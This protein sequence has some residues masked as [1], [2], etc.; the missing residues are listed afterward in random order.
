MRLDCLVMVFYVMNEMIMVRKWRESWKNWE[1]QAGQNSGHVVLFL[2]QN[3]DA[4]LVV[5]LMDICCILCTKCL[6]KIVLNGCAK[7]EFW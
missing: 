4:Y 7:L 3:F 5:K 1:R 2:F 6:S